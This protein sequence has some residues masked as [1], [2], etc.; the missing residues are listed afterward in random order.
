MCPIAAGKTGSGY[1]TQHAASRRKSQDDG[2]E[3][4]AERTFK[5]AGERRQGMTLAF[6]HLGCFGESDCH[7][8]VRLPVLG[9][10]SNDTLN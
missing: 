3:N 5:S 7:Q 1:M 4:I 9:S 10:C 8:L 6:A 2:R